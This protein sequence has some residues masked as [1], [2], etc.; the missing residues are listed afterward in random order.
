M[1][2]VISPSKKNYL[3]FYFRLFLVSV[4]A[5]EFSIPAVVLFQ[6]LA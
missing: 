2:I 1:E 6:A 3:S 4:A 5:A